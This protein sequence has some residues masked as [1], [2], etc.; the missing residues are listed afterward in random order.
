MR[1]YSDRV[2]SETAPAAPDLGPDAHDYM[3]DVLEDPE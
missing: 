2:E 3:S 1:R